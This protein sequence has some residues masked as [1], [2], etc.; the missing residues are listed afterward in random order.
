MRRFICPLMLTLKAA[1]RLSVTLLCAAALVGAFGCGDEDDASEPDDAGAGGEA[2]VGGG[3]GAGGENA[4]GGAAPSCEA[5]PPAPLDCPQPGE[6]PFATE[7]DAFEG[8]DLEADL[9]GFPEY[10]FQNEDTLTDSAA[11][12]TVRG[13]MA[14]GK[15]LTS[16]AVPEE[17]VSLWTWNAAGEWSQIGRTRTDADGQYSFD[18]ADFGLGLHTTYAV[19]EGEGSCAMHAIAHWPAGTQFVVTDIDETLTTSD[20]ELLT[21]IRDPSHDPARRPGSIEMVNAWADKG[22]KIVY[23]TARPHDFRVPTREWLR[24]H[25]YPLGPLSTAS[26][27]VFGGTASAYKGAFLKG[28]IDD[29]GWVP[30]AAYGN[31]ESDVTGYEAAGIPKEVSFTIGVEAGMAGTVAI[32]DGDYT[33]H[34]G[35][36]VADQPDAQQPYEADIP[37]CQ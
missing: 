22:Y 12:Q 9:E 13:R 21:Q 11:G 37:Y 18:V 29:L 35:S 19:L 15:T 20:A 33:A 28:L 30:V 2:P 25:G 4:E 8:A 3:D 7:S 1:P 27:L 26:S 31:A 6:L 5:P 17:W 32:A 16:V 24:R 14:R 23:L 34:V 36:Y 10:K